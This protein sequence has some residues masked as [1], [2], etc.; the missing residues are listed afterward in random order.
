MR[1]LYSSISLFFF[2]VWED[3]REAVQRH[4]TYFHQ[5][6]KPHALYLRIPFANRAIWIEDWKTWA[7]WGVER[8]ASAHVF[9]LGR[10]RFM[11]DRLPAE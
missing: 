7:G 11:W 9:W 1:G 5:G 10:V 8:W 6:W 3:A 4:F 2:N